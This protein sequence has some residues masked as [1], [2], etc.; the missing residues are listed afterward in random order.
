MKREDNTV[1]DA[2]SCIKSPTKC[3]EIV[4]IFSVIADNKLL[5]KI[6][7]GYEKDEWCQNLQGSLQSLAEARK[8]Q[9]LLYWKS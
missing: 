3:L 7:A 9:G 8:S 4:L 6:R 1:A 5:D 2:L